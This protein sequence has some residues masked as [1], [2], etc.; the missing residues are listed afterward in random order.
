MAVPTGEL[1]PVGLPPSSCYQPL[2][3]VVYLVTVSSP[4]EKCH[5]NTNSQHGGDLVC[6]LLRDR[7]QR[8]VTLEKAAVICVRPCLGPM[9]DGGSELRTGVPFRDSAY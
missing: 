6:L 4:R 5:I 7:G 2:I 9:H 8:E 3:Q 1:A